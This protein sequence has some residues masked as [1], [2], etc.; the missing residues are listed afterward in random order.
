MFPAV[1]ATGR[2]PVDRRT[3]VEA[4]A[5]RVRTGAPWCDLPE[6]FGNRNTI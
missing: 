5:W 3:V 6:R 1:Q 4:T 2:A